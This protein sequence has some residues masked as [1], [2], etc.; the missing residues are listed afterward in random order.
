ME[1]NCGEVSFANREL[2]KE[3]MDK[4]SGIEIPISW[5][6]LCNATAKI[7]SHTIMAV[8]LSGFCNNS[9]IGESLSSERADFI[10]TA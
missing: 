7:S 2:L 9:L 6:I 8:G 1:V 10:S 3:T 5:Q 4:S